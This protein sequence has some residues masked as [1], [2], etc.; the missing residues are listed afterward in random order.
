MC[1]FDGS[2]YTIEFRLYVEW[3]N[4]APNKI[5]HMRMHLNND[6]LKGLGMGNPLWFAQKHLSLAQRLK[7]NLKILEPQV[8]YTVNS[9]GESPGSQLCK[10]FFF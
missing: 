4:G 2:A 1:I 8:H 10:P 7:P 6:I 5:F 3:I 9:R